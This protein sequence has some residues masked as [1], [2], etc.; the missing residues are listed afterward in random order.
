MID[1]MAGPTPSSAER[2][3]FITD[4]MRRD[5]ERFL[6]TLSKGL[7][8]LEDEIAELRT[9]RA[10]AARR[11]RVFRLYDTF[12]F[13]VDLTEDIL[14]GRGLTLDQA[15]FDSLHGRAARAGAG[16]LEGQRRPAVGE[17]STAPR[18]RPRTE[19]CGY[20]GLEASRRRRGAAG[21]TARAVAARGEGDE[22]E[23][24]VEETP[25]YAESGGQV[26]DRGEL[27]TTLGRSRR[28]RRDTQKPVGRPDRPPRPVVEGEIGWATAPI[29]CASTPRR[30]P[31]TVRNHS[32]RIC[33]TPP[34]ARCSAPRRCRRAR[35]WRPTA[36]A[37]TSPT[38]PRSPTRRSS[39]SR[40]SP[41]SGSSQRQAEVR[42]M[43]YD[44]AIEAGAVAIFEEK[45]GDEVRV[46][47]FGDF[48]TEL[49]GG[50]HARATG[51][52]GLLKIVSESGIAAGVRRIEALTGS[53][54]LAH[55]REQERVAPATGREA[56]DPC[57]RPAG[58]RRAAARGA[59]RAPA[60]E[61]EKL[62][63]PAAARPPG[64]SR[65]PAPRG[66]RHPAL[67]IAARVEGV[68]GKELRGM[69]DD[70]RGKLG[71]GVVL[72]APSGAGVPSPWA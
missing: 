50:T 46:I 51:D 8:L 2:R 54:A 13:P 12:G 31:A 36:C 9:R 58:S 70:L 22:V 27:T 63:R 65:R 42:E 10:R 45:Y 25:F 56:Q 29:S 66:R 26:G 32:A 38:T 37:S 3:A 59:P 15:G 23:L 20:D 6:E 72:L 17:E 24:V 71:S 34:C 67:W 53:G 1:E 62:R 18:R 35:W 40:I 7:A 16:C 55:M 61:L 49:C 60:A 64:T 44:E 39:A 43:P 48:S 33:C 41:T 57:G 28:G 21:R 69:V 11:R 47:S 4:R 14:R 30:G 5:E 52:I 19:F 68:G